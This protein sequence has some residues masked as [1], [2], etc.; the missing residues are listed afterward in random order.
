MLNVLLIRMSPGV[1]TSLVC[2][3]INLIWKIQLF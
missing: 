1:Y 2:T 3:Y